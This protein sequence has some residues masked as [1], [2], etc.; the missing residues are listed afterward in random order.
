MTLEFHQVQFL[1]NNH[2]STHACT[3]PQFTKTILDVWN[4]WTARINITHTQN[5]LASSGIIFVMQSKMEVLWLRRLIPA[6]NLLILSPSPCLSPDL[7]SCDVCLWDGD[8]IWFDFIFPPLPSFFLFCRQCFLFPHCGFLCICPTT[9]TRSQVHVH[10]GALTLVLSQRLKCE[11]C[12]V[13]F[14]RRVLDL[15]QSFKIDITGT[16][17]CHAQLTFNRH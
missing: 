8:V 7:I 2:R 9:G 3:S 1:H 14:T 12:T 10:E 5:T 16:G 13:T 17:E 15:M 11:L 6:C 4:W